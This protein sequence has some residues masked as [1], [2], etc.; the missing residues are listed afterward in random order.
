MVEQFKVTIPQ[1]S[2]KKK[3][4]RVYVY[5]PDSFSEDEEQ[6]YPVLYMFDGHNVF[7]DEDAT[8]GKSWGVGKYLDEN[9]VHIMVVAVECSHAKKNGRLSEYSPFT[10]E[11]DTFGHIKGRGRTT[12]EWFVNELK[13][14]IDDNYPSIPDREA[15]WIA[16]SSMGGLMALYAVTAYNHVYGRAAALS[17][18]VW[19][20]PRDI[21]KL[22]KNSEMS[23]DTVLYM[24]YG[25]R[26]FEN[27]EGMRALYTRTVSR[28]MKAGIN[29]TSRVV[30]NGDHT[31][32]CWEQQLP[33]FINT[34]LYERD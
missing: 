12:M 34:L 25:Q 9:D 2:G 24:D 21:E 17:P 30:P 29:L 28:L 19:T 15:T 16:G 6:C 18:S 22:I 5:I 26:E 11:D 3:Q 32:E 10:F 33:F 20:S 14:Y 31:E 13:P 8:Y 4:R 23:P 7:F 1:L 27:H